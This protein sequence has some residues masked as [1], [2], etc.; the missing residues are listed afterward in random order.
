M[1]KRLIWGF[2]FVL[3][4]F[5]GYSILSIWR[6]VSLLHQEPLR[7]NLERAIR[8]TPTNPDPYYRLALLHEWDIHQVSLQKSLE[9]LRK[10]IEYNPLEQQY[11]LH[12]ANL[13]FRIGAL[14]ASLESLK[15]GIQ[16]FPTGYQ[17]RWV[18]GNLLLQQ[19]RIEE[20]I[21]HFSYILTHYPTQS[22]LVYDVLK[23][24]F[25]DFDFI[26]E[27]VIPKDRFSIHQ[28]LLYL[29]DMGE[30]ESA[31]K[32][33]KRKAQLGFAGNRS[34]TLQHIEF[35]IREKEIGEAFKIWK[36]RLLDEGLPSPQGGE[37]I[38]N[39]GFEK[40]NLLGGGFDWKIGKVNGAEVSIDASHAAEGKHSLK[41][42]FNGKE[43]VDFYHVSQYVALKPDTEYILRARMKTQGVTTKS[44]VKIEIL[45]VGSPFYKSSEGVAG[46]QEWKELTVPFRTPSQIKG[47]I[48][49]FR[50]ERTE[51]FDRFISGTVWADQISLKVEK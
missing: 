16:L 35:L 27:Q 47:G 2:I 46:D 44:G 26:F 37:L 12:Q 32:V 34:E 33:W 50:R 23:R 11:W 18:G 21:P 24:A 41:I 20:A 30:K 43:N 14:E 36:A 4:L 51:K 25:A 8:L 45:G 5:T 28:Y 22:Y 49:R 6:G 17:G 1:K 15:K 29:Y 48:V 3:S 31:Q 39:G 9:T 38:S 40:E 7:E 10:A 19:K 42:Q 13:L